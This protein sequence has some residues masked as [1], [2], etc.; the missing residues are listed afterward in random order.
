MKSAFFIMKMWKI[1]NIGDHQI[2]KIDANP[3]EGY[4]NHDEAKNAMLELHKD[5]DWDLNQRGNTFTI[6]EVFTSLN[7]SI[8][9]RKK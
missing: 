3:K 9:G 6:M 2:K 4:S 1:G 7:C 5:G 8:N